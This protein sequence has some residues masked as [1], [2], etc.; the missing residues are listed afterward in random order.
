M[1]FASQASRGKRSNDSLLK[2]KSFFDF[3]QNTIQK[4]FLKGD[5]K[6]RTPKQLS[7]KQIQHIRANLELENRRESGKKF[8]GLGLSF[9]LTI[10]FMALIVYVFVQYVF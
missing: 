4:Y 5:S 7:A 1:S 8:F 10:L 6:K 2:K 9:V 3:H